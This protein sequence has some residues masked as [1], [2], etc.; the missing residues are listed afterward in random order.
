MKTRIPELHSSDKAGAR[1]WIEEMHKRGLLFC[2]DD[3]PEDIVNISNGAR[4]F[5]ESECATLNQY[6]DSLY[7]TIGD[8]VHAIAFD[9]LRQTF[10]TK[11]EREAFDMSYG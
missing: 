7:Q 1:I 3:K 11:E 4:S 9:A 10:F 5:T 6:L 8:D 2:M